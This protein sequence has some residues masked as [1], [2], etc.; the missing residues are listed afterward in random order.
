MACCALIKPVPFI[1]VTL[2]HSILFIHIQVYS[3]IYLYI[4]LHNYTHLTLTKHYASLP[5]TFHDLD[6]IMFCFMPRDVIV[7]P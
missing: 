6:F 7:T 4:L 2:F 1:Y 3:Y 5:I